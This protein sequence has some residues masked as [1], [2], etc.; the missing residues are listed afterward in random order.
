MRQPTARINRPRVIHPA[1]PETTS[2][3][4]YPAKRTAARWA[5]TAKNIAAPRSSN[6][7]IRPK[8]SGIQKQQQMPGMSG[9]N[10]IAVSEPAALPLTE[11]IM[12]KTLY[13]VLGVD[14]LAPQELIEEAYR[15]SLK[16]LEKLSESGHPELQSE[17]V[18]FSIFLLE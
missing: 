8:H 12:K 1:D 16:K 7:S 3:I 11:F 15:L 5:T 6:E 13:S 4:T 17:I 14:S 10:R 9:T 18:K 2:P